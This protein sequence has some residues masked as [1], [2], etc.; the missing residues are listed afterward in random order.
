M[1]WGAQPIELERTGEGDT[2]K[3]LMVTCSKPASPCLTHFHSVILSLDLLINLHHLVPTWGTD[4]MTHMLPSL[5]AQQ[6][7]ISY[8]FYRCLLVTVKCPTWLPCKVHQT[9]VTYSAQHS[10]VLPFLLQGDPHLYP[11]IN[12]HPRIKGQI[13]SHLAHYLKLCI[14]TLQSPNLPS[15]LG[16]HKDYFLH[17][18]LYCNY[19]VETKNSCHVIQQSNSGRYT[20]RKSIIWKDICI[21]ISIAVLFTISCDMNI[22]PK[23]PSTGKENDTRCSCFR[24]VWLCE[25]MDCNYICPWDPR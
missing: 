16:N 17:R 18:W 6:A 13:L 5:Q 2:W 8:L 21:L 15:F 23:C 9:S 3:S 1:Q 4:A 25:L 10:W 12:P 11:G 14:Y 20:Q 19:I 22:K 7:S 24:C